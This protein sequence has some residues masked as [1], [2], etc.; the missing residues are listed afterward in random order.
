[1][2]GGKGNARGQP[3]ARPLREAVGRSKHWATRRFRVPC[4]LDEFTRECLAR[5]PRPALP[6]R[7]WWRSLHLRPAR[8]GGG[9]HRG[10]GPSG[11]PKLSKAQ[12]G[13]PVWGDAVVHRGREADPERVHRSLP[14]KA[15]LKCL[16]QHVF[17]E[18]SD[19]RPVLTGWR[20]H[21]N[22]GRPRSPIGNVP[23]TSFAACAELHAYPDASPNWG[24]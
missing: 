19:L 8:W 9:D 15:R 1:M 12:V 5:D 18:L 10:G 23:P 11:V 13:S 6:S 2:P 20:H 4:V 24:S 17:S 21:D 16:D 7:G 22:T 3:G 14:G